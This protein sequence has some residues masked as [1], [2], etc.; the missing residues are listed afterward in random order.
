MFLLWLFQ[1][2]KPL[3]A[4]RRG[5]KRE[6][7]I[8][9]AQRQQKLCLGGLTMNF[10]ITFQV[11]PTHQIDHAC[12]HSILH[13]LPGLD[14]STAQRLAAAT[15]APEQAGCSTELGEAG[16][17]SCLPRFRPAHGI[18][19][20]HTVDRPAGLCLGTRPLPWSGLASHICSFELPFPPCDQHD[21][22]IQSITSADPLVSKQELGVMQFRTGNYGEETLPAA[23]KAWWMLAVVAKPTVLDGEEIATT[24]DDP[25]CEPY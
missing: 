3:Y 7:E 15:Q 2:L 1:T 19:A 9:G 17:A 25:F 14:W 12:F 11:L 22:H 6:G 4:Q 18:T 24:G 16:K 10:S 5:E 8:D 21:T 23:H 13:K 20:L